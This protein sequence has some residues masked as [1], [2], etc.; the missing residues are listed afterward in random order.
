MV[1]RLV[2][3]WDGFLAGAMLVSGRVK[4]PIHTKHAIPDSLKFSHWLSENLLE[5]N[6]PKI[7]HGS[8]GNAS[9]S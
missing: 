5:G 6:H 8:R 4:V 7:M 3:F 9:E 2:S 1:G